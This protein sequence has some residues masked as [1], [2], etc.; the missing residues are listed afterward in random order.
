VLRARTSLLAGAGAGVAVAGFFAA[1]WPSGLLAVPALAGWTW[2]IAR[3]NGV[4]YLLTGIVAAGL[5]LA[6]GFLLGALG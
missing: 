6:V 2:L 1:P 4:L 3:R 5:G